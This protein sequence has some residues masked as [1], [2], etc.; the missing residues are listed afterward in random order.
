MP[1][2][3]A[4]PST[5]PPAAL[6]PICARARAL[7][8]PTCNN[9]GPMAGRSQERDQIIA[10]IKPFITSGD[11][12]DQ[13]ILYISG[14][15]GTGKTAMV[16]S[17]LTELRVELEAADIRTFTINCMAL[18]NIEA[19]WDRFKDEFHE[20]PRKETKASKTKKGKETSFETVKRILASQ[21]KKWYVTY[22]VKH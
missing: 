4:A 12:K 3:L 14:S 5:S 9:L 18:N 13:S 7:L 16:N 21:S 17:V 6:Q 2:I 1:N 22:E 19:L 15:P 10:F 8:R 11:A 20:E